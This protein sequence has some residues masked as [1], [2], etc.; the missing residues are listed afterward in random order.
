MP[1]IPQYGTVKLKRGKTWEFMDLACALLLMTGLSVGQIPKP[2][3]AAKPMTPEESAAGFKLPIGFRMDAQTVG[4]GRSA[5]LAAQPP[6][7]A[8]E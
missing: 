5:R 1:N 2:T 7:E 6:W 8:R 4:Y 3:D